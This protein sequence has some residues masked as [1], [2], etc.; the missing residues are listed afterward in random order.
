MKNQ[1]IVAI[2]Y[3]LL[4]AASIAFNDINIY[5]LPNLFSLIVFVSLISTLSVAVSFVNYNLRKKYAI[6]SEEIDFLF[7]S[8]PVGICRTEMDGRVITS[9][10]YFMN[11]FRIDNNSNEKNILSLIAD[12]HFK[13]YFNKVCRTEHNI[14]RHNVV[15]E[16]R[17]GASLYLKIS[18]KKIL[19]DTFKSSIEFIFNDE[20]REVLLAKE[21]EDATQL[22][23]KEMREKEQ[24]A[25]EALLEKKRKLEL[26]AKINHEVRTPL[27]SILIYFEMID[28]GIL[29]S[30][31]EIKK[32]SKSVKTASQSLLQT[33]NN[34]VDYVKIETGKI[35]VE[36]E[37]FNIIEELESIT[38][39]LQPLAVMK[40]NELLFVNDNCS[41]NLVFTDAVKFRQ[42]VINLVANS[43][44]FTNKGVIKIT[45]SVA[46][47][48]EDQYE[49]I[50]TISDSG[51][52]IPPEKLGSIFDPFVSLKEGDKVSYSSG[53][54]L[55]IC[56]EF[57]NMLNGEITVESEV[58]LGTK[59][60]LR[61]PYTYKYPAQM[62]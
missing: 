44:K 51:A 50:T 33:I 18:A 29:K 57:V 23:L 20:T 1:I 48:V 19:N 43:I 9:N 58:G 11:L 7:N 8:I 25:Q 17:A 3:N 38:L 22:L 10:R 12:E 13:E 21:K 40:N 46:N 41:K 42:V 6:R 26:L 2:Y 34:F 28:D 60:T 5:L 37:L 4:F 35:E 39:L 52:G 24:I 54:G 30:L 53:L 45:L 31:D 16:N 59:F 61:I 56:R 47:K 49:I 27:N 14:E 62:K 55:T 32:Y 36:N 15:V